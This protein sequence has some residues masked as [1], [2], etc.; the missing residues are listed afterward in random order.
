MAI[1]PSN[2]PWAGLVVLV[3][4]K[5]D[6]LKFCIDLRKLNAHTIKDS[7]SLPRIEDILNSLNGAVW[8]MALDLKSGYW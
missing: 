8:F 2:I 1:W 4:K 3:C 5:A 7:Y 6:K